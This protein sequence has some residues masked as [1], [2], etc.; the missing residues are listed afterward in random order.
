MPFWSE[1]PSRVSENNRTVVHKAFPYSVYNHI[2]L[3]SRG[4]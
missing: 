2:R 3:D 4:L 1:A